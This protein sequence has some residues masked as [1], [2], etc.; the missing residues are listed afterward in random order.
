MP[1]I[2]KDKVVSGSDGGKLWAEHQNH[3]LEEKGL[4][5]R[6]N[7]NGVVFQEHL[8]PSW[9]RARTF[10]LMEEHHRV[11]KANQIAATHPANI[12]EA[13][14]AQKSVFTRE[15]VNYFLVKHA[16][17]SV[18]ESLLEAFWKQPEI[19]QLIN[20]ETG[21]PLPKFTSQLVAQEE[22]QILRI[23]SRLDAKVAF[24]V[25]AKHLTNGLSSLTLEQ[26]QVFHNII[27]GKRLALIQGY[28]GTEKS[29]LLH[30]LQTTYEASGC[31][32]RAF[33]PDNA[34][35]E[36]LK[37]KGLF[38]S[39]NAYRFLF[40]LQHDR[41]KILMK[42]V[43]ILDEAGKLGN[44]S[45]LE[46]LQEASKRG[47]QI[48]LAGDVHQL[49]PLERGGMFKILCG[50]FNSQVLQ[51]IHRQKSKCQREI[52]LCLAFGEF[53]AGLD[54]LSS[55]KE[56]TVQFTT[57]QALQAEQEKTLRRRQIQELKASSSLLDQLKG[58]CIQ[59]WD[60][61]TF[62]TGQVTE[63]LRDLRACLKAIKA[64]DRKRISIETL[65][66]RKLGS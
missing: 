34:A 54:Q 14:T 47:V 29:H 31:C 18:F 5:L 23:A 15:D 30:A 57:P 46:F 10:A 26:Q 53:G 61:F 52:S 32:V 43:W 1:Q 56:L 49:P 8:D 51:Q 13:I 58:Y 35:V 60:S 22:Q 20:K 24:H 48:I 12:L 6:V 44:P 19:I 50:Q 63:Y 66:R 59:A 28:A 62:Q 3:D 42:E 55:Q 11:V 25:P 16:P 64:E 40:A 37:E 33:A 7:P 36:V 17:S 9:M 39:E 65:L 4:A 27:Q 45:L 38:H 41:R 21:D 2:L